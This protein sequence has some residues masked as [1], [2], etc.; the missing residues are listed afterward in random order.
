[1]NDLVAHRMTN[2]EMVQKLYEWKP[3]PTRLTERPMIIWENNIKENLKV[4][5]INN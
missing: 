2:D 5:K 1:M 3:I 4:I